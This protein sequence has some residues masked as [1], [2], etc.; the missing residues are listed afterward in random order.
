MPRGLFIIGWDVL[1]GA[2]ITVKVPDDFEID[3]GDVQTIDVAHQFNPSSAWI[4]IEDSSFKVASVFNH[5][6]QK[7]LVL[8]LN[9]NE[10]SSTFTKFLVELAKFV[11]PRAD[12][13]DTRERLDAAFSMIQAEV[14]VSDLVILN[15]ANRV[16]ELE[17]EK[18][19]MK[20][21][22]EGIISLAKDDAIKVLLW[23]VVKEG[24]SSMDGLVALLRNDERVADA[25]VASLVQAGLITRDERSGK[26]LLVSQFDQI[27]GPGY[28][29]K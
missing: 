1:E 14:P 13:P 5:D 4:T 6:V 7:A 21:R 29:E 25:T 28:R 23:L 16:E 27:L 26:V 3:A 17:G 20:E 15:L 24:S 9:P 18:L 2:V 8:V 11:L 12:R 19:D 10:V 22:I